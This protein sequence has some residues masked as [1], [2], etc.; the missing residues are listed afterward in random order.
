MPSAPL[1]LPPRPSPAACAEAAAWADDHSDDFCDVVEWVR[2]VCD[3]SQRASL[4]VEPTI[5]QRK[6]RDMYV[7]TRE[8]HA[9]RDSD[10][11]RIA[12]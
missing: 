9:G 11:C 3:K 8:Q 12:S 2:R 1:P 10:G 7:D 6:A 4:H 5:E